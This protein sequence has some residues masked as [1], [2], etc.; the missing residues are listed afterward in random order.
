VLGEPPIL[1]LLAANSATMPLYT[2]FQDRVVEPAQA[3]LR[4]HELEQGVRAFLDGVI[5]QGAFDQM[6]PPVREVMLQNVRTLAPEAALTPKRDPFTCDD[7]R[8]IR[9]PTL[10]ARGESSPAFLH[11]I[12]E[13]LGHCLPHSETVTI[14]AASH[15]M[16]LQNPAAYNEAVLKFFAEH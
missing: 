14:P 3:L 12:L 9:V 15:A 8:R 4:A 11:R 13:E 1:A 6:P 2:E 7:A 5:G 16:H 10:L